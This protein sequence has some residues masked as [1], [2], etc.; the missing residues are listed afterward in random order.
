L[1]ARH[2]PGGTIVGLGR[3]PGI[4][5]GQDRHRH[6]SCQRSFVHPIRRLALSLSVLAVVLGGTVAPATTLAAGGRTLY[7][8]TTGKDFASNGYS[9]PPNT[10]DTPWRTIE[11][12]I[13]RALPGDTIVVR[14][15]TYTEV[16]GWGAVKGTSTAPIRLQ[17]ADG[18]RVVLKGI[19]ALK[20]ADYWIVRGINVT[21]DPA[22]GRREALVSFQGGVGWQFLDAEVW[23][24]NGVSNIM[25]IGTSASGIPKNYR[26]AGN[27][28]HDNVATGDSPMTDHNIYL[29][30]GYTSGPGVIERNILFNAHNGANIKA[31]GPTSASGT[32]YLTI[33]YNTMVRAAA[34]V[35]I[36]YGSH[37]TKLQRNLVGMQWGGTSTYIAAYIGN[38]LT[39]WTNASYDLAVWGYRKSINSVNSTTR[40]I[41]STRSVWVRPTFDN[42]TT[43]AGF[44]PT[45]ATSAAY[46]R[47]AP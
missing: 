45:D 1:P 7:V 8:S 5:Y 14:G 47:Y 40:P 20:A 34:G 30:P 9:T 11:M 6:H 13:R 2:G 22:L 43:C 42:T 4:A 18:E 24:S 33:R 27:C 12:A 26:I 17:A 38:H 36:G 41:T 19:L 25:V 35:V 46:G 39:G 28:V 32:A 31:A 29:Y 3:R 10:I 44:H 15:G 21:R 37:H 23:G 16:A